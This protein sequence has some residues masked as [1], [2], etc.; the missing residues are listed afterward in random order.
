[1]DI[2]HGTRDGEPVIL[3]QVPSGGPPVTLDPAGWVTLKSA[4]VTSVIAQKGRSGEH[5]VAR[6]GKP[7]TAAA[8]IVWGADP[9]PRIVF[10]NGNRRDLR[11]PN[12]LAWSAPP[13]PASASTKEEPTEPD[14]WA[15]LT[16]DER[17]AHNRAVVREGY[18]RDWHA[19]RARQIR[20]GC[21]PL[22][23]L[24]FPTRRR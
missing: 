20:D 23:H 2:S 24:I 10:A 17:H 7:Q 21:Y 9:P 19:T 6:M 3:L 16:A 15:T 12:L 13:K 11:R 1:M 14:P 22:A 18:R 8:R 4:G 5:I